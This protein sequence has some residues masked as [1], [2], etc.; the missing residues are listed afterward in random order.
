MHTPNEI[1]Y[2]EFCV[3]D[4]DI[5]KQF[6]TT[7]FGWEFTDYAKDY[8]GIKGRKKEM[9]GF[10]VSEKIKSGGILPVIYTDDLEATLVAVKKE[11]GGVVKDIFSFPGERRFEF[12]D[13]S[14]NIVAVWSDR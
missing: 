6:Y 2:I 12:S 9:G 8:A 5:A 1:D 11:G 13:P 7:V 4:M 14:G 3:S 10:T